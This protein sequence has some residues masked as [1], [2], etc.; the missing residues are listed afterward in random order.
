MKRERK[1]ESE[2]DKLQW[3][4]ERNGEREQARGGGGQRVQQA[5]TTKWK[6][7]LSNEHITGC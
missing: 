3:D 5:A 4:A 6:T 1:Y 2:D 7:Q